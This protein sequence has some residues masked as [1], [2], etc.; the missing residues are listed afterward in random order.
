MLPCLRIQ[1][2]WKTVCTHPLYTHILCLQEGS[3]CTKPASMNMS[4]HEVSILCYVHNGG[5]FP[6]LNQPSNFLRNSFRVN[7]MYMFNRWNSHCKEGFRSPEDTIF[8][9]R[10]NSHNQ[11]W[12]SQVY[13]SPLFL[14]CWWWVPYSSRCTTW[15]LWILHQV[16]INRIVAPLI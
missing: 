7:N 14:I 12:I 4:A 10:W 3:K 13:S 2:S 1:Y 6:G 5:I 15:L 11:D 9:D 16:D 8:C